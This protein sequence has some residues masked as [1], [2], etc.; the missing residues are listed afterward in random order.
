MFF[1][2]YNT[3]YVVRTFFQK[4]LSQIAI[5]TSDTHERYTQFKKYFS[6]R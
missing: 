1:T 6:K 3:V 2:L 4:M 5:A